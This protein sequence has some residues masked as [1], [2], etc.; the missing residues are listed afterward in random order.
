[1][2]TS[3]KRSADNESVN[4]RPLKKS[5]KD[6]TP[7]KLEE[8]RNRNKEYAHESRRRRKEFKRLDELEIQRLKAALEAA[9][10]SNQ[11][12]EAKVA[13]YAELDSADPDYNEFNEAVKK[14]EAGVYDQLAGF[15]RQLK[16]EHEIN[17]KLAGWVGELQRAAKKKK[18]KPKVKQEDF[19]SEHDVEEGG[20]A[21]AET[22]MQ[23]AAEA[24]SG[25]YDERYYGPFPAYPAPAAY[26]APFYPGLVPFT[27]PFGYQAPPPPTPERSRS[28]STTLAF[29][30]M[31]AQAQPFQPPAEVRHN[32]PNLTGEIYDPW[33]GTGVTLRKR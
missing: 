18:P 23:M 32:L 8:L 14:Y 9:E 26:P 30:N 17:D 10:A 3:R 27:Y 7:E 25:S 20:V 24:V 29:S 2:A 5:R 22:E 6:L 21:D 1:M 4:Q 16:K 31:F 15:N 28:G 19:P 13:A 33:V 11:V 12:L